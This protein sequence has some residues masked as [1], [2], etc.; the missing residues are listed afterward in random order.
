MRRIRVLLIEDNPGDARLIRELLSEIKETCFE[1][2]WVPELSA[3]LERLDESAVDMVLIDLSLPD[4]QQHET[5]VAVHDRALRQPMVVLTGLDDDSLAMW[6]VAQGAQDYLIKD[7]I[8]PDRLARSIFYALE[9]HRLQLALHTMMLTDDLTGLFNRRGF[10]SLAE[11]QW[12][13]ARRKQQTLSIVF[14]DLDGLKQINDTFGHAQGSQAL[15]DAAGVLKATF[16][17]S[18]IIARV[19]GD[20]FM[21]LVVEA[22]PGSASTICA[23]VQL[24]LDTFN[25]QSQRAYHLSLSMGVATFDSAA[26]QSIDDLVKR[27]DMAMYAEKQRKRM[28]RAEQ[29]RE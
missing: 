20:E 24:N 1:V 13:V 16:R 29:A 8:D 7:R 9:R 26:V 11:E 22:A 12:K 28:R 10:L 5:L 25:A 23:R 2:E 15:V 3:G 17:D 14:I 27:A 4:S 6:A 21:V 18:D 19:G